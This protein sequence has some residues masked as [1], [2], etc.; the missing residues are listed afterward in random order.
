MSGIGLQRL[1]LFRWEWRYHDPRYRQKGRWMI[2]E[3]YAT[4]RAMTKW[5]ARRAARQNMKYEE[6]EVRSWL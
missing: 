1:G 6:R 4:G 2:W 5:G 3:E